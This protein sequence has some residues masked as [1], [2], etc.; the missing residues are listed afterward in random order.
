MNDFWEELNEAAGEDTLITK[1]GLTIN[2]S[3]KELKEH[4]GILLDKRP[5][6]CMIG[7]TAQWLLIP[8]LFAIYSFPVILFI[9]NNLFYTIMASL[10]LMMSTSLFNQSSYNYAINKYLIK[11]AVSPIPK[12][13]INLVFA[14]LLYRDGHNVWFLMSPFLWWI[15]NDRIPLIYLLSELILLKAKG[16]MYNLADPDGVLRQVGIYWAKKYELDI[17]KSGKVQGIKK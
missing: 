8:S 6:E 16:W 13:L 2:F 1:G 5:L 15:L 17:T 4:F 12:A 10:G 9:S 3:R 14:I 7:E 11:P